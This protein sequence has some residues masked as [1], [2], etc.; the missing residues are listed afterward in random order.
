MLYK[1][2]VLR[3]DSTY[4]YSI[5]GDMYPAPIKQEGFWEVKNNTIKLNATYDYKSVKA[6]NA[7]SIKSGRIYF[8]LFNSQGKPVTDFI[9]NVN[10]DNNNYT[11]TNIQHNLYKVESEN[12]PPRNITIKSS[13]N[14]YKDFELK[15]NNQ[16]KNIFYVKLLF[17]TNYKITNGNLNIEKGTYIKKEDLN[18]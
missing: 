7:D 4:L 10:F 1:E 9:G 12:L 13:N 18:I 6:C 5:E 16:G 8:Y 15:L 11:L 3:P 2:L 17:T 14:L